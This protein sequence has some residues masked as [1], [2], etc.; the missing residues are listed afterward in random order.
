M[1]G[2]A[3]TFDALAGETENIQATL[4]GAPAMLRDTRTTLARADRTLAGAADLADRVAPG[5]TEARRLAA[6]LSGVLDTVVDVGPD[7]RVTLSSLRRAAPDL[8]PLL[9]HATKLM[10]QLG[11][12]G[13]QAKPQLA[14]VRPY[15]PEINSFGTNWGDWLSPVDGRDKYGRANVQSLIPAAYNAQTGTSADAVKAFPGLAYAFPQP[16]GY[17]AGQPWFIPECGVGPES[18]DPSK[19]PESRQRTFVSIPPLTFLGD[20]AEGAR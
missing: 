15:T 9:E 4:D 20:P 14:C 13:K 7:A 5:V 8:N 3:G 1:T 17:S 18:L 11:S 6:P 19:D 12:I 10:P 2:A 16:P